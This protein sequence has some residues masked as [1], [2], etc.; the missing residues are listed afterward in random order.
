MIYVLQQQLREC[1]EQISSLE[2]ENA[3]LRSG[4]SVD[5]YKT[6]VVK[7]RDKT[8]HG[9]KSEPSNYENYKSYK[10]KSEIEYA[11]METGYYQ[12]D[13]TDSDLEAEYN[14]EG[15]YENEDKY[16][17]EID[18]KQTA[19]AQVKQ[20]GCE[21]NGHRSYRD[22]NV[23]DTHEAM[24]TSEVEDSLKV[25]PIE[26]VTSQEDQVAQEQSSDCI[27]TI[28]SKSYRQQATISSIEIDTQQTGTVVKQTT[29]VAEISKNPIGNGQHLDNSRDDEKNEQGN[30]NKKQV[31]SQEIKVELTSEKLKNSK[32]DEIERTTDTKKRITEVDK[33]RTSEVERIPSPKISNLSPGKICT[34]TTMAESNTD[35]SNSAI[36]LSPG[37]DSPTKLNRTEVKDNSSPLTENNT[38]S[39]NNKDKSKL[40]EREPVLQQF[41]NG[42]TSTVDDIEDL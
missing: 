6:F 32:V 7:Q 38:S 14:Y 16:Q 25:N 30:G 26:K 36:E 27:N 18:A 31:T 28:S 41:L 39:S 29:D 24:D 4:C 40:R 23:S 12:N 17:E 37:T 10:D 33:D 20:L 1:K 21:E 19:E 2:E 3:Q 34:K 42:I 11:P 8:D 22:E 5:N 13:K 9:V 15:L 35:H